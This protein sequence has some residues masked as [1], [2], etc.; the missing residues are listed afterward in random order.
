MPSWLTALKHGLRRYLAWAAKRKK[1][2]AA[3]GLTPFRLEELEDRFAPAVGLGDDLLVLASFGPPAVLNSNAGEDS[4]GDYDPQITTDGAG[5]WVAVWQSLDSLGGTIGTDWDILVSRS[6][7]AGASWTDPAPLNTNAT[8]DSGEDRQPQLTTDG[9]G[10]WVA[11]WQSDNGLGGTI[12]TDD[13]IFFS[14]STD[15]GATWSAP[16]PLNSNAGEDSGD[17]SFPPGNHRRSG[18]LGRRLELR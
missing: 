3:F 12:G 14:R 11:V 2:L 7:D 16:A 4:G 18:Q 17:D 6:T 8:E 13:D 1:P 9:A 10:N 5:N 15:A